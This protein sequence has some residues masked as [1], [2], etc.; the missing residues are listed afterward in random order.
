M[1]FSIEGKS[2]IVTGAA[3]GVGL[4]IA[5]RFV[6]NGAR[7]MFV[8][9]DADGLK[10]E[11]QHDPEHVRYFVGDLRKEL[12]RQNLLSATLDEFER[13]DILVNASR[14]VLQSDIEHEGRETLETMLDQNLR[15]NYKLSRLI[16]RRF[17]EQAKSEPSENHIIGSIINLTS[18]AARRAQPTLLDYS[19]SCAAQDQ[20][21]RSLAVAL[22]P[23]GIRV[24]GIGFG[25]VMSA[26]LQKEIAGNSKYR[27]S[28]KTGTPMLRIADAGEVAAAAQFLVSD[29]ARFITGHILTVDGGRSLL[30]RVNVPHH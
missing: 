10:F 22:A 26:K 9:L 5:R 8:D 30:D 1:S 17:I 28:I 27:E 20:L 11:F 14:Q 23:H 15:Q 13:V 19:I 12:T 4:A 2:T 29:G 18:I 24:N 16:A 21:T 7:V 25:S 3:R 6:E